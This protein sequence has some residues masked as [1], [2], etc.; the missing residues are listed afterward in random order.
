MWRIRAISPLAAPMASSGRSSVSEHRPPL[1]IETTGH[2]W[3]E[4]DEIMSH[5]GMAGPNQSCLVRFK[6]FDD[7]HDKWLPKK[8][9]NEAALIAYEQFLREDAASGGAAEQ[10]QLRSF[11][12]EREV[13]SI[14]HQVARSEKSAA[15]R[16]AT[17]AAEDASSRPPAATSSSGSSSSTTTRAG[18]TSIKTVR[19]KPRP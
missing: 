5:R 13:F 9:I 12:G 14:I 10:K 18:R 15:T 3:Y 16:A 7:S 19:F 1:L 2:E 17:K 6:D 8:R 4:V 11:V